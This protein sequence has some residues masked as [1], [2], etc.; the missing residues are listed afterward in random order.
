[1]ELLPQ[2]RH[3]KSPSHAKP[4]LSIGIGD[5]ERLQATHGSGRDDSPATE[6]AQASS[7][8]HLMGSQNRGASP[9]LRQQRL[10]A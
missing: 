2:V 5:I 7:P 10:C 3:L 6:M 8:G 4:T 9:R 1:M